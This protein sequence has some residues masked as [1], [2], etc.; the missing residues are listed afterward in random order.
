MFQHIKNRSQEFLADM[1]DSNIEVFSFGTLLR[2]VIREGFVSHS[3]EAGSLKHSPSKY[4]EPRFT[5]V[6]YDAVYLPDWYVDGS[7]PA[8]ACNFEGLEKLL[9]SPISAKIMAASV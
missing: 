9:I 7:S 8:N 1:A 6:A 2:Q 3:Y 4:V 5:I